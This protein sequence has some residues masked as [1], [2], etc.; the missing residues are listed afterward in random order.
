MCI[1]LQYFHWVRYFFFFFGVCITNEPNTLPDQFFQQLIYRHNTKSICRKQT[2]EISK[3]R[4]KKWKICV[5]FSFAS[6]NIQEPFLLFYVLYNFPF[7]I[8]STRDFYYPLMT[9]IKII[10]KSISKWRRSTRKWR[11]KK[12]Q[13]NMWKIIYFMDFWSFYKVLERFKYL[14]ISV[15]QLFYAN[16]FFLR[17]SL[18]IA[19]SI[20]IL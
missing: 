3:K 9:G 18:E 8:S 6:L 16:T 17:I 10:K 20:S 5:F 14:L 2:Y 13:Q 15:R 1:N 11:R 19:I 12:T 4:K 7:A